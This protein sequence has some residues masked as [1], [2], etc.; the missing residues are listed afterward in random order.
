MIEY[1]GLWILLALSLNMWALLSVLSTKASLIAKL[2]WAVPLLVL[3]GLAF[4]AWCLFGPRR[5][6]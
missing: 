3:P 4:F 1:L 2:L 6:A 5:A